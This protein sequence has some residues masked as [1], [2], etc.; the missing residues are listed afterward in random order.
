IPVVLPKQ[1]A[2]GESDR[3]V[4]RD[5]AGGRVRWV[6]HHEGHGRWTSDRRTVGRNEP[7]PRAARFGADVSA[8][9]PIAD[10]A[11]VSEDYAEDPLERGVAVLRIWRG[12]P[13]LRLQPE[14]SCTHRVHEYSVGVLT[15]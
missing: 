10:G 2:C 5:E 7:G 13:H 4:Q 8:D 9:L 3:A 1:C 11:G 15:R 6:Q 12:L 14:L